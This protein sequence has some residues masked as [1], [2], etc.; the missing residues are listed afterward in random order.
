M[1]KEELEQ[2]RDALSSAIDWLVTDKN[3][4]VTT[5]A[6]WYAVDEIIKN[7][8]DARKVIYLVLSEDKTLDK[9]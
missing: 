2:I 8:V 9:S 1:S 4:R 6:Q 5:S 7:L 3:T